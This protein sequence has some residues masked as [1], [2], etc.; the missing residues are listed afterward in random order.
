MGWFVPYCLGVDSVGVN[1][2][3]QKGTA[4][5]RCLCGAPNLET[6]DPPPMAASSPGVA[7]VSHIRRDGSLAPLVVATSL[8]FAACGSTTLSP[9]PAASPSF[10]VAPPSSPTTSPSPSVLPASASPTA[11][12]TGFAFAAEDIAAY[13]E[14][15]GLACSAPQPST[16]AAGF[17]FRTCERTDDAGRTLTIGLVTDPDG[18]LANGF[19]S[20]KGTDSETILAPIDALDPL[21]G[22]LGAML[23]E[24]QGATLLTWLASHLGDTYA[25]TTSGPIKVATYTESEEDQSTLYVELAN[26]A[27]LDAPPVASP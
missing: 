22:F 6:I 2:E 4:A 27:Y 11:N 15:Q 14:S 19:A 17:T 1:T 7:L 13:Y 16:Q 25:E 12:M 10:A 18:G 23:G 8:L 3:V 5:C 24:D 9:S 26:S 21:A 20:V